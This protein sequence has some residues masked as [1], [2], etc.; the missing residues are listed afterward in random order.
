MTPRFDPGLTQKYTGELLRAINKDGSFNVRRKGLVGLAANIYTYLVDTTW[1]RLLGLVAG[2]FVAVNCVFALI[3]VALGPAAIH[4]DRTIGM[5]AFGMDFFFSAQT[6]TTVGYGAIYPTGTAA[7]LISTLEVTLG[8]LGFAL[9]TGLIF[10]RFSRP[11]GRLVFSDQVIVAPYGNATSLQFR[12]ANQRS[13]VMAEVEARMLLM[14]VEPD[15]TGELKRNF[16]ELTLE[17]KGILFLAL[18]WT[19]VHLIDEAS[20]LWSR[21]RADLQRMQAELLILIKGYDDAFN[22]VVHS[23]YSYRW[24]EIEW[25]ARFVPAFGLAPEGHMLLDIGKISE[26]AKV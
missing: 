20:P 2:L 6:L 11:A 18:T 14:T 17:R 8:L 23:R 21:S 16:V 22:Q 10:A 12:V 26:T 4:G 19:I 5:G 1:P 13:S 25:S 24:N 15:E 3:Y 9:V 7:H